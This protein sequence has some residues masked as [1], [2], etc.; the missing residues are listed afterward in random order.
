MCDAYKSLTTDV[1]MSLVP[2]KING[3]NGSGYFNWLYPWAIAYAL[4]DSKSK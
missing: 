4:K 2:E 1:Q 3:T